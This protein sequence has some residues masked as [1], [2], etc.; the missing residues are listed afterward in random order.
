MTHDSVY[1]YIPSEHC[2]ERLREMKNIME[3]LPL[4]KEF[5]WDHPVPFVID[6]EI[7]T[8]NLAELKGISL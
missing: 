4:R 2:E 1:G 8:T 3:T 5:D 7:S 6:A